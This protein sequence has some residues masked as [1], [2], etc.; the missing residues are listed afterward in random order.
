MTTEPQ[1]APSRIAA[2]MVIGGQSVDAHEDT[3]GTVVDRANL[4]TPPVQKLLRGT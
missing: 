2:K 3:G 4:N 1:T